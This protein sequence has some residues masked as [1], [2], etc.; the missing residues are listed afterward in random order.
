[1]SV[2]K[3]IKKHLNNIEEYT[4][5]LLL[6]SFVLLLFTQILTRQLFD[7][8]IPWEGRDRTLVIENK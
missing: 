2:A 6:A 4:C 3:T 7:Y 1:M 5:C 8:S